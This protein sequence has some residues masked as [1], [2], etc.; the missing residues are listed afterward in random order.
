MTARGFRVVQLSMQTVCSVCCLCLFVSKWGYCSKVRMHALFFYHL[1]LVVK[2]LH[3]SLVVKLLHLSLVV[4]LLHLSL[5]VKLLHLLLIVN[6]QHVH[7][8]KWAKLFRKSCFLQWNKII[9]TY[10]E[11]I[12]VIDRFPLGQSINHGIVLCIGNY[13]INIQLHT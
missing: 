1:S 6:I 2:L 10:V 12:I 9:V 5:V 11:G 8:L 3:L 4:K 13:Y 7:V